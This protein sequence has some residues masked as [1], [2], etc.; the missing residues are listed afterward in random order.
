MKKNQ[1]NSVSIKKISDDI[2]AKL[3]E[4]NIVWKEI[5]ILVFTAR[6]NYFADSTKNDAYDELCKTT[7]FVKSTISKLATI[8]EFVDRNDRRVTHECMNTVH[9]WTTL[10]EATTLTDEQ[11]DRLLVKLEERKRDRASRGM[12]LAVKSEGIE[13]TT[14]E[15]VSIFTIKVDANAMR[16]DHFSSDDYARMTELLSEV[17]SIAYTRVDDNR[18]YDSRQAAYVAD[19]E[20]GRLKAKNA[21]AQKLVETIKKG[22]K[23]SQRGKFDWAY[24]HEI[25]KVDIAHL[26]AEAMKYDRS[27]KIQT[28]SDF[29][30]EAKRTWQD[31]NKKLI[32]KISDEYR[33]A[34]NSVSASESNDVG[35]TKVAA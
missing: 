17:Q 8:G 22:L 34:N 16:S 5:A 35:T 7:G 18:A 1:K 12:I 15:Y 33:Y 19:I 2:N 29:I 6:E 32:A 23:R 26:E 4:S 28:E 10:Y 14:D 3:V 11:F 24:W 25:A 21:Y 27:L 9:A 31:R 13:K 20:A 30:D